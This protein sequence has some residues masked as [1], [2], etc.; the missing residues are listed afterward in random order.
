MTLD[1][2]AFWISEPGRGELRHEAVAPPGP[3]D[4]VVR[5]LYSGISRG[6]EALVFEG[7]VPPGERERMRAP[8]QSG[9]FPAPV[10]YGYSNVGIVES[11]PKDFV[12]RVV[13]ALYPHQTRYC[14]PASA[15]HLI[16]PGVPAGR[17]V[18]AANMETAVTGAWDAEP[19]VGERVVV[20]GAGSVGCLVAWLMGRMPGTEVT[21]VDIN[22]ARALVARSLGV[23][24]AV[25]D[26]APAE[27][28]LVVHA[29]GSPGGL[30]L[31]LRIAAFEATIVDMSWYGDRQVPLNLGEAFHARR[32]TIRSSQVG[33]IPARQ[34]ARWDSRRR[35]AVAL[36]LLEDDA[37]DALITGE[38]AF[39]ELPAVMP[40]LAADPAG[41]LCHRIRY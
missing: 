21:L 8:F 32:L 23:G 18:L 2:R 16:P 10:K 11:G 15:V 7:R 22:P 33:H 39:E 40:R 29:S 27:A 12:G 19:L 1:A 5:T 41:T 25:P 36:P 26:F 31:A 35:M 20:I 13:F 24:F 38:S 14:V 6:T 34:R 3:G 28:D 4:V 17:A 9:A 30:A 37:L